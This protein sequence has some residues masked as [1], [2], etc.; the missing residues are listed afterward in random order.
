MSLDLRETPRPQRHPL[1]FQK[2][3]TLAVGISLRLIN[4]HD[5]VPLSGQIEMMR[6]RVGLLGVHRARA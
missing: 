3:D 5:P 1:I 2:F 6:P 4:D